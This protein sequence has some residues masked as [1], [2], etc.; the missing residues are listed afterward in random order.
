M[1]AVE[2]GSHELIAQQLKDVIAKKRAELDVREA[3]IE[4]KLEQLEGKG[5]TKFSNSIK[6]IRESDGFLV[7]WVVNDLEANGVKKLLA[8]RRK[9][10]AERNFLE[11]D[12]SSVN[13]QQADKVQAIGSAES[14]QKSVEAVQKSVEGIVEL[15]EK[16]IA[17]K[18]KEVLESMTYLVEESDLKVKGKTIQV[19]YPIMG[20]NIWA[21]DKGDDFIGKRIPESIKLAARAKRTDAGKGSLNEELIK[22]AIKEGRIDAS[23]LDAQKEALSRELETRAAAEAA[24]KAKLE[25]EKATATGYKLKEINRELAKA[26]A[27]LKLAET[28]KANVVEG[29]KKIKEVGFAV[30]LEKETKEKPALI[31]KIKDFKKDMGTMELE[32]ILIQ[33]PVLIKAVAKFEEGGVLKDAELVG[34][35]DELKNLYELAIQMRRAKVGK[36]VQDFIDGVRA[37][38][39]DNEKIKALSEVKKQNDALLTIKPPAPEVNHYIEGLQYQ[40]T[41]LEAELKRLDGE[42][43]GKKLKQEA[44]AL[45]TKVAATTQEAEAL[46]LLPQ[47]Q[48]MVGRL[49]TA[50][51]PGLVAIYGRLSTKAKALQIE[52]D[53]A[54]LAKQRAGRLTT[55][56]LQVNKETGVQG[57]RNK[58]LDEGNKLLARAHAPYTLE[59]RK[60]TQDLI[61]E[62]RARV[63]DDTIEQQKVTAQNELAAIADK[64]EPKEQ[65]NIKGLQDIL[66]K[67]AGF[68]GPKKTAVDQMKVLLVSLE[69]LLKKVDAGLAAPKPAVPVTPKPAAPKAPKPA[70]PG[71]PV[72]PKPKVPATPALPKPKASGGAAAPK[73][74]GVP[75]APALPGVPG[76]VPV[77]PL[78]TGTVKGTLPPVPPIKPTGPKGLGVP[79]GAHSGAPKTPIQQPVSSVAGG[80]AAGGSGA[81]PAPKAASGA[82]FASKDA[83]IQAQLSQ[84]RGLKPATASALIAQV[85]KIVRTRSTASIKTQLEKLFTRYKIPAAHKARLIRSILSKASGGRLNGANKAKAPAPKSAKKPARRAAAP[86]A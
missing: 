11:S 75:A 31:Q 51:H 9:V 30:R 72:T 64:T 49:S 26:E 80:G 52:Q 40:L 34:P 39:D 24:K 86:S 38:A 59:Q 43:A 13:L 41:A 42:L 20:L 47:M 27:N 53:K 46:K 63:A 35:R 4:K 81:A 85:N 5:N 33:L 29:A 62:L 16:E 6:S 71:V 61:T 55:M 37:Q 58:V 21:E 65:A 32:N 14:T 10:I 69:D 50:T 23:T 79:S 44:Q 67:I 70:V 54:N 48:A 22:E 57:E 17:G 73:A 19:A 7:Q 68:E 66:A 25:A 74:P 84:I 2:K 15:Y 82:R 60:S 45:D 78:A 56:G 18:E 28:K 12:L 77:K 8:L 3:M 83:S 76:L 1:S 36:A